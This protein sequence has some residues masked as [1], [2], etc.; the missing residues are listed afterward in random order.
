MAVYATVAAVQAGFRELDSDD[1]A[2]CE[3]LLEEA[4]AI[5]D[6][7]A[8][9]A[10][11]EAKQVVSCRMVRRAIGDG[12]GDPAFPLGATQGSVSALGYS[13]SWAMSSGSAGELYLSRLE[14][15]LLGVGN[16]IGAYSPVEGLV[17]AE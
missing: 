2:R 16:K 1:L 13:Q 17:S 6:S 4:G 15:Q 3:A 11:E 9:D 7:I 14:K 12:G 8:P 5:I 10:G